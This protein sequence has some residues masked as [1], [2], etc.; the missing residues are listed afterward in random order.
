MNNKFDTDLLN[1]GFSL[2]SVLYISLK[3]INLILINQWFFT[4]VS[5]E[6]VYNRISFKNQ[7]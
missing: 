1:D 5:N 7:K 3:I 2:K 4:G 6:I